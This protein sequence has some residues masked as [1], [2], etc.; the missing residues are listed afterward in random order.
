MCSNVLIVNI[1]VQKQ[2]E[3]LLTTNLLDIMCIGCPIEDVL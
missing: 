2:L 3:T 1:Y